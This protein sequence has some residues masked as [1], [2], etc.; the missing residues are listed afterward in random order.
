MTSFPPHQD[1]I[2]WVYSKDWLAKGQKRDGRHLERNANPHRLFTMKKPA[3]FRPERAGW[4]H[5]CLAIHRQGPMAE[6]AIR[7]PRPLPTLD[8]RSFFYQL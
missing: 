4:N 2:E 1:Q 6:E 8:H 5:S 3:N 7:K